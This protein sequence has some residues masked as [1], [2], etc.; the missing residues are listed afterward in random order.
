MPNAKTAETPAVV[1][2]FVGL[3]EAALPFFGVERA[4]AE[5]LAD[6]L[7]FR[8]SRRSFF[9]FAP[10]LK[11]RDVFVWIVEAAFFLAVSLFLFS[12]EV[13]ILLEAV[14]GDNKVE[15]NK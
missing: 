15:P 5:E 8:D 7:L 11:K 2:L 4:L 12:A 1:L 10:C 6:V 13:D 14:E 9:I 3:D